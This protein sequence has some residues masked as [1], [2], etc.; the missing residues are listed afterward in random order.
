MTAKLPL[1]YAVTV[2]QAMREAKA[3]AD[4][5][6]IGPTRVA[7][8][9]KVNEKTVRNAFSGRHDPFPL[10]EQA[11]VAAVRSLVSESVTDIDGQREAV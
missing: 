8:R 1:A 5:H 9:A 2:T 3:L 10:T 6:N 11:I 4:A 7:E